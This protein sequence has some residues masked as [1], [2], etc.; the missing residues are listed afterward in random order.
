MRS[1]VFA[2][3]SGFS[4]VAGALIV[5]GQSTAAPRQPAV[6]AQV[7][8]VAEAL[9][10][11]ADQARIQLDQQDRAHRVHK[12]LSES[13]S[14]RLAGHWFDSA[15]GKLTVA[16]TSEDAADQARAEGA[17]VK[18]VGRGQAELDRLLGSVR[19]LVGTGVPG[20]FGWGVDVR[21]NV[22]HVNVNTTAAT[23]STDAF[24]TK[25]KALGDGV[26]I[27][28]TDS[29]PRQQ[30][31]QPAPRAGTIQPGS[32]WWPGTEKDYC[33]IGFAVTDSAGNKHFLT[34]GHC[35]NNVNQPAYGQS[36]QSNKIGTS[37]VGGTG[38][39]NGR[40]G[41]MGLV[42]VTE[43]GWTLSAAVN[44]WGSPAIT[45]TGQQEAMV[46][47]AVCHSGNT[48][49]WKCGVVKYTHKAVDYGGSVG[50]I[51]DMTWTDACSLGGD[52]GGGWLL[53]T[54][55]TGLH[56][57]G[58]S[59]CVTNPSDADMS[60][61]QPIAEPLT[62]WGLTLVT[63]GGS[64]TQAPTAPGNPRSTGTTANTVALAWDAST[65]N[66]AVTGYDVYNG[67]TVAASV[68][69]L[70]ATVSGLTADTAYTFT[71]KSKDAA[72]NVSPA[73]ASVTARTQPG[74]GG[75]E[76]SP[77]TPSNPRSTGTTVT[78]VS[79]AWNASTDNTGVTGYDVF[80]GA[81]LATSV[82]GTSATVS[83]LTA[84]T[85]YSFTIQAKDAAGNKSKPTQPVTVKTAPGTGGGRTL[86]ND[87][88]HPI[89]DYTQT[90]SRITST[91]TGAAT[92]SITLV[93]AVA[94]TCLEDL[95][96]SLFDPNGK[97]Y[98]VKYSGGY[99]CTQWS[100]QK[101]FTVNNVNSPASGTWSLRITDY[102]PGD[103][104][105]LDRWS[106]TL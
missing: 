68:T 13:L 61:F 7:S 9:G 104:G 41:D 70:N 1:K 97:A 35:T 43:A 101:T 81:T 65:D 25:V 4:V 53:G 84:D 98:P 57:G 99:Q 58:P 62:K 69:G 85:G 36:G 24:L 83:G 60:I 22:V 82:A 17:E 103:T 94:H 95:G 26:R 28:R 3:V 8:G 90:Y 20:V 77:T 105:T 64:D 18:L 11:S 91:A 38:S 71:V 106:I 39:V 21:A 15:T 102:G 56:D 59:Q 78:T 40:E 44:T 73:S 49:K 93:I 16:V 75:D 79:L 67:S 50:V 87:T 47:D 55:A 74:S 10:I 66:V 52:S 2:A 80:N 51:E 19:G 5:G 48:S 72:G 89:R 32:P 30:A 100:G 12:A 45:V 46:G 76:E 33:S 86:T 34:A 54:K 23:A 63:G 37:N 14:K 6:D 92:S 29:A 88:D 27:T 31:A 42:A 96:I